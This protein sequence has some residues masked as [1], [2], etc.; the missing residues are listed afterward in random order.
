M[1]WECSFRANARVIGEVTA[2]LYLWRGSLI[3]MPRNCLI[4]HSARLRNEYASQGLT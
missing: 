4:K 3:L 2:P 1:W